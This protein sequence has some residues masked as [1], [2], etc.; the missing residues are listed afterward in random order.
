MNTVFSMFDRGFMLCCLVILHTQV[1]PVF[2][3]QVH[4]ILV[5][6]FLSCLLP[7]STSDPLPESPNKKKK[8]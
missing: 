7:S 6:A 2:T 4:F 8:A 1:F 3:P 5:P